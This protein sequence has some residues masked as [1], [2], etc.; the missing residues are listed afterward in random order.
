MIAFCNEIVHSLAIVWLLNN[1]CAFHLVSFPDCQW[2]TESLGAR[3]FLQFI[4]VVHSKKYSLNQYV[5]G[6]E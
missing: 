4:P 5:L 6:I 1:D 2:D 3:L